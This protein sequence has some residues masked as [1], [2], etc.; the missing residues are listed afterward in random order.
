ML[1]RTQTLLLAI[2]LPLAFAGC[3]EDMADREADD[4]LEG[5]TPEGELAS[6]SDEL[7][8]S[9]TSLWPQDRDIPTCWEN[10]SSAD[11]VEREWVRDAVAVSWE[12]VTNTRFTGWQAC[13]PTSKGIRIRIR[14][15][16]PHAKR[17]R[18][19]D[20]V[21]DGM[22]LNFKFVAFNLLCSTAGE[23]EGCIRHYATHEFGH[24]LGFAHEQNRPD[25][26]HAACLDQPDGDNGDMLFGPWDLYSIMNYCSPEAYDHGPLKSATDVAGARALY[27]TRQIANFGYQAGS[28]RA[29]R[30]P[31]MVA[32]VNGDKRDDVVGFGD[33]GVV[34]SLARPGGGFDPPALF[35]REFGYNQGWRMDRHVRTLADVDGDGRADVVGFNDYGVSVALS[36]GTRF[37]A[38]SFLGEFGYNQGWRNEQHL[39]MLADVNGDKRADVIGFGF[40]GVSVSFA[41]GG[42]ALSAPQLLVSDFGYDQGWRISD[43]V[44]TLA[45]VNGDKRADVVGFGTY[46]TMVA[47]S[48]GSG[49]TAPSFFTSEFGYNAGYRVASHPRFVADVDGDKRADLVAFGS[50]GVRVA[51]SGSVR[52]YPSQLTLA[53]MSYDQGWRVDKHPRFVADVNRDGRADLIGFGEAGVYVAPALGGTAVGPMELWATRYSAP[54]ALLANGSALPLAEHLRGVGDFDAD[55]AA[56]VFAFRANGFHT[57]DLTIH[58]Q[59]PAAGVAGSV[60]PPVGVGGVGMNAQP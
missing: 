4:T 21:V 43:H 1:A 17:G 16:R 28:W 19:I 41:L 46:G 47:L 33:A 27:G 35:I 55:G 51:L 11:A 20:G 48:T 30:H 60:R 18:A 39:R 8:L 15:E 53:N 58:L 29:D 45:D 42:S 54:D 44:R 14:D 31:R 13:T 38:P 7:Y 40:Y 26:N 22:V 12:A 57:T 56:D 59:P 10:P 52:F 24:A 6:R 5:A 3:A 2:A 37:Y 32:D 23:R 49:F 50:D 34:V 9:S 36:G 25:T